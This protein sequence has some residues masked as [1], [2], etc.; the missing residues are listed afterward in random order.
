M[1]RYVDHYGIGPWESWMASFPK[2]ADGTASWTCPARS[3]RS[4]APGSVISMRAK[5]VEHVDL[6]TPG[7]ASAEAARLGLAAQD[8]Q[9]VAGIW[10]ALPMRLQRRAPRLAPMHVASEQEAT[11]FDSNWQ[12]GW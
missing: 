9:R 2:A 4:I 11:C 10:A 8:R 5:R 6:G 12:S 3:R 1:R 7:E